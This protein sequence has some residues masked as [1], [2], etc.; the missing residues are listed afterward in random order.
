MHT[1]SEPVVDLDPFT[2]A[3]ND[4]LRVYFDPFYHALSSGAD[5]L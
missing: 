3:N 2:Y 1:Y 4:D 5:N